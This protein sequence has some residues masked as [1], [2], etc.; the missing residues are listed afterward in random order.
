M[1][2]IAYFYCRKPGVGAARG[3]TA[4]VASWSGAEGIERKRE[5]DAEEVMIMLYHGQNQNADRMYRY[6][7]K[8]LSKIYTNED[9]HDLL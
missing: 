3:A 9:D 8:A 4:R 7:H 6:H 2:I 5:R 1:R